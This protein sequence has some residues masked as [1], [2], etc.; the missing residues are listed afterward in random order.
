MTEQ[1]R[2][3]KNRVT[4]DEQG[5]ILLNRVTVECERL[6]RLVYGRKWHEVAGAAVFVAVAESRLHAY[7][8]ERDGR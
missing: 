6:Q 7:L 5:K 2:I 3:L 1:E 8:A 4:A